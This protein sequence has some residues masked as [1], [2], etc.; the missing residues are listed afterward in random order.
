MKQKKGVK[1]EEE[2]ENPPKTGHQM[3]MQSIANA[4]KDKKN[5]K[6]MNV[7]PVI[8]KKTNP[9]ETRVY[10]LIAKLVEIVACSFHSKFLCLL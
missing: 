5:F 2:K 6:R 10:L 1:E 4:E 3:L 7:R 8:D 9:T